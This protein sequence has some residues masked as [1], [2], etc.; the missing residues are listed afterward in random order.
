[1]KTKF[2]PPVHDVF[3]G[4]YIII[5][6]VVVDRIFAFGIG[7]VVY[8]KV[9]TPLGQLL[10]VQQDDVH[11]AA[12]IIPKAQL[13]HGAAGLGHG[14]FMSGDAV[15]PAD[16]ELVV[17]LFLLKKVRRLVGAVIRIARDAHGHVG[18]SPV[19]L[20]VSRRIRLVLGHRRRKPP[21]GQRQTDHNSGGLRPGD[22]PV[23]VIVALPIAA[24]D[25][26]QAVEFDDL[27]GM[28]CCAGKG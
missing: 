21:V 9:G 3:A 18:L 8:N 19:Y 23:W 13:R 20:P 10:G 14:R 26:A 7:L 24:L 16:R 2:I 22:V 27:V 15:C 11:E 4:G 17:G 5:L 1:M 28:G 25:N 6:E 12:G